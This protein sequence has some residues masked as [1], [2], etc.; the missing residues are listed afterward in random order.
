M[1]KRVPRYLDG[2]RVLYHPDIHASLDLGTAPSR[3]NDQQV[4]PVYMLA[5]G[6][7]AGDN[8][9]VYLFVVT[10]EWE[11]LG[12]TLYESMEDAMDTAETWY[13][14]GPDEWLKAK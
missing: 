12:D 1:G 14:I 11:V 13:S 7:Y 4:V 6:Q 8:P 9:R 2:A 5:I 3:R 10:R